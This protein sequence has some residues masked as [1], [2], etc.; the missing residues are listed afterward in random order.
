M[1]RTL[2][3]MSLGLAVMAYAPAARGGHEH[4]D[5]LMKCAKACANC[6]LT[7]DSCFKHCLTLAA[8][9]KKEHAQSARYC[10]D[11]AECC[12]TCATLCARN[13]P[14]ARH[15]LDGCAKCCADCA[16]ACA[17]FPD[18][19]H[20]AECATVC[21]DCAKECREMIKHVGK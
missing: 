20:M 15:M 14:L 7:C 19:R 12:K 21:R 10:A 9:G 5:H 2:S 16:A 18:D 13:S 6:Q 8:N 4:G 11:C 1:T 3:L 17:K